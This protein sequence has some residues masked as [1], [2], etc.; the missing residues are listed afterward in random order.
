MWKDKYFSVITAF[1][2]RKNEE[3]I[4]AQYEASREIVWFFNFFLYVGLICI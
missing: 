4:S 1:T 2:A 3:K